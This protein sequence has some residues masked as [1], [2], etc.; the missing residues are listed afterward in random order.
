MVAAR[1]RPRGST[2][3]GSARTLKQIGRM[4]ELLAQ[5]GQREERLPLNE[6]CAEALASG[7]RANP[8]M[9]RKRAELEAAMSVVERLLRKRFLGGEAER[10]ATRRR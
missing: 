2:R 3:C 10:G 9:S 1:L 7:A 8:E 4:K 6:R 5:L